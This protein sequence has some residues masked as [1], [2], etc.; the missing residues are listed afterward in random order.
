MDAAEEEG[1]T[2]EHAQ[3]EEKHEQQEKYERRKVQKR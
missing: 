2:R 3:Q 1:I